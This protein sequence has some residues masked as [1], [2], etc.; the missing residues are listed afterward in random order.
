[1]SAIPSNESPVEWKS[2]QAEIPATLMFIKRGGE[3][4]LIEK[5]TGIGQGKVNGPGG[6]IDPGET[7]EEAIVRECQEE[8][9]ITPK[10]AVKMG[11]LH[12]A[13]SDIPDIHCH[14]FMATEFEGTPT[15]TREANPMWT[16]IEAI[17]YDRMWEDDRHWLPQ[18]L[19]GQVFTGRFQFEGE[20][21]VWM[22]VRFGECGRGLWYGHS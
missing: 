18:M 21:I 15:A 2:W 9:H 14:V 6:K 22:D 16:A 17:P 20:K 12:F 3:V 19:E 13:M 8:L 5:L 10:G 4:L 11:E 7:A 1:M